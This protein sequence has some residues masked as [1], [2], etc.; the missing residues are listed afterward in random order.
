MSSGIFIDPLASTIGTDII[1]R[2]NFN[3]NIVDGGFSFFV[4]IQF[5]VHTYPCLFQF[6][7]SNQFWI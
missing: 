5:S 1:T 6:A 4:P 2:S 7:R 3:E